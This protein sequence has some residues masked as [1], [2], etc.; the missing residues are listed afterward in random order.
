[1][2][3]PA[4]VYRFRN[5][6]S[7]DYYRCVEDHFDAFVQVPE[8]LNGREVSI[9]VEKLSGHGVAKQMAGDVQ[10]F[11][12]IIFDSLLDATYGQGLPPHGS[13]LHQEQ[14]FPFG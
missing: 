2:S 5:P 4:S 3:A 10:A 7:S 6:Q 13:L 12:R 14:S 9:G 8:G 11:F 1:M